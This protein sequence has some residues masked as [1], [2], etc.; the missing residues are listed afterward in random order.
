ME[1]KKADDEISELR[2][3]FNLVDLDKGGSICRGE[4]RSLMEKLCIEL[5]HGEFDDLM[6]SINLS[7]DGVNI[8]NN[9]AEFSL[10]K[11]G[12]YIT[13]RY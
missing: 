11:R 2:D 3:I 5:A 1:K 10:H 12:E 7:K 8:L 4:L 9:V 6:T 13:C